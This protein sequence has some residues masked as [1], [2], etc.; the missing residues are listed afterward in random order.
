MYRSC[1]SVLLAALLLFTSNCTFHKFLNVWG[2]GWNPVPFDVSLLCSSF[3]LSLS[4]F[5]PFGSR[6]RCGRRGTNALVKG[7]RKWSWLLQ[8]ITVK[9]KT[10]TR[11]KNIL[12]CQ[13][14]LLSSVHSHWSNWRG[15][16]VTLGRFWST[17]LSDRYMPSWLE[18][19]TLK[20]SG[21][22]LYLN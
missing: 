7:K 20:S 10:K 4:H 11:K 1:Q 17:N 16:G 19:H 14:I 9:L 15:M 12:P 6:G 13:I 8:K 18:C 2:L 5:L 3:S 21:Q 22:I